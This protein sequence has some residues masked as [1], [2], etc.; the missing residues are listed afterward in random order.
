MDPRFKMRVADE[1][2]PRLER[3]LINRT[4]QQVIVISILFLIH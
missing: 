4:S 2:W 1:V 3:E